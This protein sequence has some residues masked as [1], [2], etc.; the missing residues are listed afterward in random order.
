LYPCIIS[1]IHEYA[2]VVGSVVGYGSPD[3]IKLLVTLAR[4]IDPNHIGTL[5]I[6]NATVS[7]LVGKI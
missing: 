4:S 1:S 6:E 3:G 7:I 2:S 5:V